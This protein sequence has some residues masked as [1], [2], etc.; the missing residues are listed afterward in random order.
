MVFLEEGVWHLDVQR[1]L[2]Q[3]KPVNTTITSHADRSSAAQKSQAHCS[4]K[5]L[6]D[7]GLRNVAEGTEQKKTTLQPLS[8]GL[9]Q[10]ISM[11]SARIHKNSSKHVR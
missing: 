9:I 4:A 5:V 10:R 11:R 3:P 6:A 1:K 8:A 7:R 2:P